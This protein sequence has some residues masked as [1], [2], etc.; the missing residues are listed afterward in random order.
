MRM[1]RNDMTYTMT[2]YKQ[3]PCSTSIKKPVEVPHKQGQTSIAALF[4]AAM[5]G[6]TQKD[7][8]GE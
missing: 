1:K 2:R 6:D 8:K 4:S 5:S 7:T 3:P